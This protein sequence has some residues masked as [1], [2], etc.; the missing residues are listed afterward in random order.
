MLIAFRILGMEVNL[1][2]RLLHSTVVFCLIISHCIK[3]FNMLW[4]SFIKSVKITHQIK[5]VNRTYAGDL[6]VGGLKNV[7]RGLLTVAT[8]M[9]GCRMML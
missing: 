8:K 7:Y 6:E 2:M 9:N 3:K 4:S 1:I 5:F